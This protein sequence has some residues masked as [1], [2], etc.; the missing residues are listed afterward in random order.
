M[1]E[2]RQGARDARLLEYQLPVADDHL[3]AV[4]DALRRGVDYRAF[5]VFE[6]ERRRHTRLTGRAPREQLDD[7]LD[8]PDG[9]ASPLRPG[10]EE[11]PDTRREGEAG[12]HLR[13]REQLA[14]VL[15]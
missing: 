2:L 15:D 7:V 6:D 12:G 4:R 13:A 1:E 5:E 3:L 14:R 8:G 9:L 10:D 11:L